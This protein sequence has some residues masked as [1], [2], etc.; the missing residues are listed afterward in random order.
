MGTWGQNTVWPGTFWGSE[1]FKKIL[2]ASDKILK[3][4]EHSKLR[5]CDK[6]GKERLLEG[7]LTEYQEPF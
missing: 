5:F 2:K 7:F 4:V 3:G 6:D 1:R